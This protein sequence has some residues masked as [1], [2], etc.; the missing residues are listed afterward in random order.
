[1]QAKWASERVYE[2]DPPATHEAAGHFTG[3]YFVTFPYPYMNGRLH[4]GHGFSLSKSEFAVR[5]WRMKGRN[6][7]WPFGLHVTGTP[8][9]ACAQKIANEM[10]Q[11]GCPPTFPPEMLEVKKP[12][13]K[14]AE[15]APG[16]PQRHTGRRGKVGP[17]L[18]QWIIMKG[19]GLPDSEIHKFSDARHWLNY[20]PPLA[21]DDLKA[22]GCHIDYRR[23]FIT[24]DVNP[25][26]D[27]FVRWQFQQLRDRNLLGFGKRYC[28]YSPLD[29]QPCADHDRASGEGVGPQE[30]TCVKLRVQDPLSH[31]AF[32]PHVAFI[33][34]KSV[35]LPAATL[36][37]ETV[38]GQ[39]NCWMSP[40]LLYAAFEVL[41]PG[42]SQPEIYV[43]TSRSARN[44]AYQDVQ[45]NGRKWHTPDPLF[46]VEGSAL[47]GLPVSAPHAPYATIF[48]LPMPTIS[49]TKGTG[50]VMSVP[51]DSPDDYINLT[52]LAKK[53]DYRIKLNLR[54]EWV[55][56]FAVVPI[57]ICPDTDLGEIAAQTVCE[58]LKVQGPKDTVNLEEAKKIVYQAGFYQGIMSRGPFNGEKVAVAKVK[59]TQLMTAAGDAFKYYEPLKS[60][61]SRSGDDCVVALC[62][63][64]F[65][66][67]GQDQWRSAVEAHLL[68]MET[69]FPGI[70][71][72]FDETLK[73]LADWPC[74]RSFGLGTRLPFEEAHGA[75]IDSLSDS[76]IYMAYYMVAKY[77]HAAADG[78]LNLDGTKPNKYGLT[79]AMFTP[80]MWNFIFLGRGTAEELAAGT[81]A[82]VDVIQQMRAE[83]L[84][85]YPVDLRVSGKD[86]IQN[87]LTMFLYNHAAIWP[88]DR[89]KWPR[90]IYCNGHVLVDGDKM[91]KS[92]G[93]FVVLRDAL[94][95]YSADST[96]LALADAGDSLDD[97]NFVRDTA[98]G[99][100]LKISGWIDS[101]KEKVAKLPTMRSGELTI[102][103]RVFDNTI[104]RTII[105]A[106]KFYTQMQFR[107]VLN[108]VFFEWANDESLYRQ[109]CGEAGPHAAVVR[110]H[111]ETLALLM[112][113]L[114]PHTADY[115]WT[116]ILGHPQS[117][118][119]ARFP[120]ATAPVDMGL[121]QASAMIETVISEIRQSLLKAQKKK[122][123][124]TEVF[125][126]AAAAY[127]PWQQNSLKLLAVIQQENGGS[128]PKDVTKLV[129][130][131][132]EPWMT[133]DQTP[134]IMAFIAF[135]RDLAT[136]FGPQ[137]LS[138]TPLN[139]DLAV[140][141]ACHGY[142]Q[143]QA[144]ITVTL[145][146]ADDATTPEHAATRG[147]ARPGEPSVA[148]PP[149]PK[150]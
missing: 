77:V 149:E 114:A 29:D 122:V 61:T 75:I 52:T 102:F 47:M 1:M 139:D 50:V 9:A 144:G 100:I 142:L 87:H 111:V 5:F 133:K 69:Y 92:K 76:T 33:G 62:D 41:L 44:M 138:I 146:S 30:Y 147:K 131:R 72:G 17:A 103:D 25:Y 129:M 105:A 124:P 85:F 49:D 68:T 31:A 98:N 6:A 53:A 12:E 93:N 10:K 83:F 125:I 19:M 130:A 60:V 126:Y 104:N 63:Q 120:V 116:E 64:W 56:P 23:S 107:A 3:K 106:E 95:V 37:P 90:S 42:A 35:V 58:R 21:L 45:V 48:V 134:E 110:R 121:E 109:C 7:L 20:F 88:D 11:F 94:A 34:S 89:S 118:M 43:M 91:S 119:H 13:E 123:V 128:I 67:Y 82:A 59:M 80:A 26:Y 15:A 115:I 74:S 112:M 137:A 148:L 55:L 136:K 2:A 71:N 27:S 66:E 28:V 145:R 81:G 24:T 117:I 97:A 14:P 135:A 8:I 51:S 32:A 96:R 143:S 57:L 79:P 70:R 39:T 86:L 101:T 54:D 18:P 108:T 36:R 150:K 113:P 78:S 73:W 22:M 40:T 141:R 4:L 132:K 65:L 84:Y 46:E 140:L 16:A 99:F 38:V 127:H